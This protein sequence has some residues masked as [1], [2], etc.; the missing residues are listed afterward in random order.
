MRLRYD[1]DTIQIRSVRSGGTRFRYDVKAYRTDQGLG[2]GGRG[3]SELPTIR[4]RAV[5]LPY[6]GICT[7]R[8]MIRPGR[9]GPDTIGIQARSVPMVPMVPMAPMVTMR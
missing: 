8:S 9:F 2:T 6:D 4:E 1:P 7:G 3:W 5:R